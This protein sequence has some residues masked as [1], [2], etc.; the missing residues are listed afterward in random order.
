MLFHCLNVA[1]LCADS[2]SLFLACMNCGTRTALPLEHLTERF[3]ENCPVGDVVRNGRCRE[4]GG[5]LVASPE[6]DEE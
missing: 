5:W 6:W 3:G 2:A 4:C 1:G